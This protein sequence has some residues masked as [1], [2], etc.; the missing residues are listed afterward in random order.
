MKQMLSIGKRLPAREKKYCVQILE[1]K[2]VQLNRVIHECLAS[3]TVL[4]DKGI[5]LLQ[6]RLICI[7]KNNLRSMCLR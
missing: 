2:S 3:G 4:A 5:L 1:V 7:G 6:K